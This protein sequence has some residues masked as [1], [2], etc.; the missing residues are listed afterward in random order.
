MEHEQVVLDCSLICEALLAEHAALQRLV[1][2]NVRRSWRTTR[3]LD[4]LVDTDE[5]HLQSL[6]IVA[7][8]AEARLVEYLSV[9]LDSR[10]AKFILERLHQ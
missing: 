7:E 10:L 5:H 6:K 8:L 9:V 1:F 2:G 3:Y 4:H